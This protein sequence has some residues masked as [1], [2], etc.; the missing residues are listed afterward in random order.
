MLILPCIITPAIALRLVAREPLPV[1]V[2]ESAFMREAKLSRARMRD[3]KA[4]IIHGGK[5]A[6]SI[7]EPALNG[8]K[9]IGTPEAI[10]ALETKW[11]NPE[12][13]GFD[14]G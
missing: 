7:R 14:Q 5:L 8:R 11:Q 9:Y 3:A 10:Q 13:N 12:L 2:F 6:M 1:A 4:E